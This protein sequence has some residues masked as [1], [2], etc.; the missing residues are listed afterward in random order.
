M[1]APLVVNIQLIR[2]EVPIMLGASLLL[3]GAL[4]RTSKLSFAIDGAVLFALAAWPT[5]PSWWCSR[6]SETQAAK[7]EF[8][9]EVKAAEHRQ[10]GTAGWA[11]AARR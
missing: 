10:P 1:I 4:P 2:Q 11:G 7:D 5:Q 6:A 8:A 3:A 9:D